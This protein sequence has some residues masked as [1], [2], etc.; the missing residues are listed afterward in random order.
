MQRLVLTSCCSL[1]ISKTLE[2]F[3]SAKP[4]WSIFSSFCTW[5]NLNCTLLFNTNE[6]VNPQHWNVNSFCLFYRNAIELLS[7]FSINISNF[8]LANKIT[9]KNN[10]WTVWQRIKLILLTRYELRWSASQIA[11][12]IFNIKNM[13]SVLELGLINCYDK[14]RL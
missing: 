7:S 3:W 14:K 11:V 1:D 2:L 10:N 9:F 12:F 4:Q 8:K 13:A 6:L 5:A